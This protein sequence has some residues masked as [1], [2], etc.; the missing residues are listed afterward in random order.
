MNI[1]LILC[2]QIVGTVSNSFYFYLKKKLDKLSIDMLFFC[3]N[4]LIIIKKKNNLRPFGLFP[5]VK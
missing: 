2:E 5:F 1:S 3:I 4:L